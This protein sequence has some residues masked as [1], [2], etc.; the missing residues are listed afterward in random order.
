MALELLINYTKCNILAGS[1]LIQF[2]SLLSSLTLSHT[3]KTNYIDYER[4]IQIAMPPKYFSV[5]FHADK[6]YRC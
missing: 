4:I 2:V 5:T 3:F 6:F 1:I